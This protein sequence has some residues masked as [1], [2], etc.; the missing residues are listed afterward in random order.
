MCT[1]KLCFKSL[2]PPFANPSPAGLINKF[3]NLSV[4]VIIAGTSYS[5]STSLNRS[6]CPS[7]GDTRTT[8]FP[9][10]IISSLSAISFKENEN[11][12]ISP[13]FKEGI[14]F[15]PLEKGGKGGFESVSASTDD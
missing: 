15:P 7:V 10:L 12:P 11:H 2:L 9:F 3:D 8:K 13:F 4:F 14:I 1:G 6:A 5:I